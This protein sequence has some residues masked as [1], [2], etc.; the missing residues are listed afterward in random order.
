LGSGII[1]QAAARPRALAGWV[2]R[3]DT[4]HKGW[5]I[6]N[7]GYH[8][9]PPT[10]QPATQQG[11]SKPSSDTLIIR[12]QTAGISIASL[13][14][15][16]AFAF[17]GEA[18]IMVRWFKKWLREKKETP[19]LEEVIIKVKINDHYNFYYPYPAK[20]SSHIKEMSAA[21]FQHYLEHR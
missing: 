18:R 11:V 16:K 4:H 17:Y 13:Q 8:D 3:S 9:L 5:L 6:F 20:E 21:E 10:L 19:S 14:P 12:A 2:E 15:K 1:K 7:G